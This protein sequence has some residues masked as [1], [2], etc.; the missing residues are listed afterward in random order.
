MSKKEIK[1]KHNPWITKDIL[2][3]IKKRENLYKHYIKAKDPDIKQTYHNKF[4]QIRNQILTESRKGK[5]TYFQNFFKQNASN[6]KNTWKGIKEIIN[7]KSL[8]K[9]HPDSLLI[10]NKLIYE[11]KEVADTFN[12]YFSSIASELQS[13]IHNHGKDFSAFLENCNPNN[14]FIKPTNVL[15][16]INNINDLSSNKALGPNSIPTDVFHLIKLSV[17]KPLVEIINLSFE[18]GIYIEDLKISRIIPIFKDKGSDLHYINYRP[19]SLLSNINKIIEKLMN[20]RL[21]S[22]LQKY[23]CI[24]EMQFGFRRGHSTNHALI[25]LTEDIR[26]AIDDNLYSVGVFIDLQKAF[27]TVDQSLIIMEL[28]E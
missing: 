27:D 14:F 6:I 21:Y 26:K 22:F 7:I 5:E 9:K 17:A 28:E 3:S 16:V 18:K 1:L 13:K 11:P 19:I 8:S 23:R 2:Q 12:N 4:K 24:Y 10:N 25:D 20:E 15:E